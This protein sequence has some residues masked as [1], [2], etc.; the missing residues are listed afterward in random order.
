MNAAVEGGKQDPS[1]VADAFLD[2][3]HA[4]SPAPS[5]TP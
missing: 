1:D 4:V 3:L 2:S 5:A